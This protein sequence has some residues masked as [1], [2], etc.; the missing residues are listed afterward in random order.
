MSNSNRR[1]NALAMVAPLVGVSLILTGCA[2]DSAGSGG[3]ELTYWYTEI[4]SEEANSV[5]EE[6]VKAWA[7]ANDVQVELVPVNG[8]DTTTKVSAALTANQLPDL[9]DMS[10]NLL[11]Q[12]S[13]RG[14]IADVTPLYEE[15]GEQYGG[16]QDMLQEPDEY[17]A[18]GYGIP[19]G[20]YGN[21][22]FARQDLLS[23]AG[24]DTLPATWEELAE[25]GAEVDSP[26][27]TYAMGFA[28]SNVAD[29]EYFV[30]SVLHSYGARVADDEGLQCTLD[31]PE[32]VAAL[33]FIKDGVDAGL[34]PPDVAVWDGAGDNNAYQSGQAAFIQN[35]GSV[36]LYLEEN[37]PE[38][39][40]STAYS[41]LPAGPEHAISPAT[42]WTHTIPESSDNKELAESLIRYLSEPEN[43][44]A[45][46]A[47]S[48]YGPVTKDYAEFEIFDQESSPALAG[49]K[50]LAEKGTLLA[51]PDT[52]NEAYADYHT[53]FQASTLVQSVVVNGVSMPDAISTAQAACQKIYDSYK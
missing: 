35:T 4:F 22:L 32:T 24:F 40:A 5:L 53:S 43:I 9:L 34:F 20:V 3:G 11:M 44:E 19:F 37:D 10:D 17:P 7:E 38:L 29:A 46:L 8:N 30:E 47:H 16:W 25:M 42:I 21:I 1:G 39:A 52:Y 27:D 12:L 48:I 26:P 28:L 14:V 33:T 23:E 36:A 41:A 31:S 50:E 13:A 2:A 15:V 51:Y 45:Y 6:Q 49:L 18:Y